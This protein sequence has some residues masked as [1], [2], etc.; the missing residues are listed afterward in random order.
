MYKIFLTIF[1][2]TYSYSESINYEEALA[3]THKNNKKIKAL[4]LD[5]KVAELNIKTVQ[6][7]SYGQLNLSSEVLRTNHAGYVFNS[8]LS[9]R[10]ATFK[11][12]GFSQMAEGLNTIPIDLNHPEA[13]TNINNKITYDI[14]LFTGFK[15]STQKDILK[16]KKQALTLKLNL[17]KKA[18][19]F[20]VLKAYNSAVVAKEY[21]EAIKKA[22]EAVSFF[23][24]SSNEFYNEG[25]VTKLD[26][27]QAQVRMY[28][29]KSKLIEA[30]NN[31]ELALAY[32]KFLTENENITNVKQLK[33]LPFKTQSLDDLYL[34]AISKR[35]DLNMYKSK[36]DAMFKNIDL[37]KA[38]YYPN[39]YGHAEY[40][41]NDNSFSV[42]DKK[43]Y[44]LFSVGL[45]YTLFDDSRNKKYEKSRVTYQKASV[46]LEEIKNLIKLE[47]EKE[48]LNVKTK[49]SILKEKKESKN[50]S[51]EVLEQ[52]KLMYKN[53]LI[54]MTDLLKQ[55]ALFREN[56]ASYI[57]AKYEYSLCIARL[58]IILGQN[59]KVK[60]KSNYE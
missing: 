40:G 18:L 51:N 25:L 56:E 36:K 10:E 39:L 46:E 30:T 12:F 54:S 33:L 5:K 20:E 9:S 60:G 47:L 13:R 26:K 48:S 6:S 17:T 23:L 52:S 24:K 21:I 58:K 45:K 16:L 53:Q 22:K 50:L 19:E 2:F 32:L 44:Y 8:K 1:L 42:D 7:F 57:M 34:E 31:F 35:D 15:L 43:D 28:N 3:Q 4:E 59:L 41:T 49:K 14:P 38:D 29:V 11:D 37:N 27:K 55:E